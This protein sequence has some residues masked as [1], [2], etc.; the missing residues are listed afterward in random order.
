MNKRPPFSVVTITR[1]PSSS[2][3]SMAESGTS[4]PSR[5]MAPVEDCSH[6]SLPPISWYERLG[7]SMGTMK[8][9]ER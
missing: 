5:A 1:K 3:P 9:V 8:Q 2:S 7:S 4:T 6:T